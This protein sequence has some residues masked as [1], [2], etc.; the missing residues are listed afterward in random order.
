MNKII[1][2]IINSILG[3]SSTS[4]VVVKL[5]RHQSQLSLH[6][7]LQHYAASSDGCGGY[8]GHCSCLNNPCMICSNA[9]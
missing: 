2:N 7:E 8:T 3:S 6:R 4:P 5:A 1:D 9:H